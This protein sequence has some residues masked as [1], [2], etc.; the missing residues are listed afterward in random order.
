V[1]SP[2][3]K[4]GKARTGPLPVLVANIPPVI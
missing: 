4:V 1:I 3:W 2:C